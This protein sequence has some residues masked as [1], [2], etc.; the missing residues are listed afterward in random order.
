MCPVNLY[1][2]LYFF[3]KTK[4]EKYIEIFFVLTLFV[5]CSINLIIKNK[6]KNPTWWSHGSSVELGIL[7][8]GEIEISCLVGRGRSISGEARG[9]G[10]RGPGFL[11]CF[12]G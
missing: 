7:G 5:E 10:L 8:Q 6:N 12:R 2:F 1:N 11:I 9:P 4:I 3:S